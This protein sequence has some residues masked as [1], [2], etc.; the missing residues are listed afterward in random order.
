MG[1]TLTS[2]S[3]T[4]Y[5]QL[6]V[7][8]QAARNDAELFET[9]VNGPFADKLTALQM[10]LG[11]LVFLLVNKESSTIDR[12]ALSDTYSA[13]GAVRMS[14]KPFHEIKIPIDYPDNY[15]AR[16]IKTRKPQKTADWKYLFAPDLTPKEARFNQAGAGIDCSIVYPIKARDGGAM[17][18]SMY[19]PLEKITPEHHVFMKRYI[20]MVTQALSA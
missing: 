13:E 9:I 15:I 18:F 1:I 19:Q 3:E 17:I 6:A 11:V 20:D 5:D 4:Y 12:I 8:L 10:D 2:P 7:L 16:A 14:A